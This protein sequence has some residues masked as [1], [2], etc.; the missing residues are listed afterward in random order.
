MAAYRESRNIEYSI[1][2]YIKAKL[3]EY[4]WHGV[5]VV[6]SFSEVVETQIPVICVRTSTLPTEH[7]R[8]EVG[9]TATYRT[10]PIQIDLF[11]SD[12]G[13]R[14][15]LKDFLV[16]I[17][18]KGMIYYTMVVGSGNQEVKTSAGKIKVTSITDNQVS[19][20]EDKAQ[21]GV[22]DRYRHIINLTVET[23]I[24]EV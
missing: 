3:T 15:D 1:I 19:F 16:S 10:V 11:A 13:N 18:K 17:L 21:I 2:D 8:V 24:A 22:K 23:K 9:G 20:G 12:D 4:N 14:L 7:K 5:S 6:K